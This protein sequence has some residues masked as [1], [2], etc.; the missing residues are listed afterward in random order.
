MR[1]FVA[2][3]SWKSYIASPVLQRV[4]N[5]GGRGCIISI[6]PFHYPSIPSSLPDIPFFISF[7]FSFKRGEKCMYRMFSFSSCA[8]SLWF[9]RICLSVCLPIYPKPQHFAHFYIVSFPHCIYTSPLP[10]TVMYVNE[11]SKLILEKVLSIASVLIQHLAWLG[12]AM[13]WWIQS[14][15]VKIIITAA[16]VIQTT[17]TVF[18]SEFP[19]HGC[20]S[21]TCLQLEIPW[22]LATP[23][24]S[25]ATSIIFSCFSCSL[26]TMFKPQK[27]KH[28]FSFFFF[29][30][31]TPNFKTELHVA[32]VLHVVSHQCL[33]KWHVH[34]KLSLISFANMQIF[35][36]YQIVTLTTFSYNMA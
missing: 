13:W 2:L 17:V 23:W 25:K 7:I 20:I 21:E 10:M 35:Q 31:M 18:H 14:I 26:H 15:T 8:Q 34:W 29:S 9:V 1:V 24:A 33:I 22:K 11:Q 36:S 27:H 30:P 3:H 28:F 19:K 4:L 6:Q 32:N 5:G 16:A 12:S